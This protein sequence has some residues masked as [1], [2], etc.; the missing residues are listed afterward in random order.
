MTALTASASGQNRPEVKEA[1]EVLLEKGYDPGVADGLMGRKTRSAIMEFQQDKDL[2]V[3]GELD[4]AIGRVV[5]GERR[6][7]PVDDGKKIRE[8]LYRLF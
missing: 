7:V 4:R 2:I 5:R 3:T 8:K 1:Q 6:P